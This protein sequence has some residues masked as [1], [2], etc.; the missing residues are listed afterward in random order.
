MNSA[1]PS[2]PGHIQILMSTGKA[3]GLNKEEMSAF[4]DVAGMP[5]TA[6]F[7]STLE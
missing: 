7:P 1:T 5:R 6:G 4:A 2:R 3:L